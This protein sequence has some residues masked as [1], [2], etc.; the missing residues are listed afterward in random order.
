MQIILKV[1][2]ECNLA[3]SYC[4]EGEKTPKR[5]LKSDFFKLVDDIPVFSHS[6]GEKRF[7]FLF[8]GGEPMLYGLKELKVL[9]DYAREKLGSYEINFLMQTNGTLIDGDWIEFFRK[10]EISPGISLD[11][12]PEIHD[13]YRRTKTGDP[14]AERI[15]SN[16]K[17]LKDAGIHVGTLM[18][19]NSP[20]DADSE[21]LFRF[22]QTEDLNP[23]I[24]PVIP[25]GRAKARQD[26][27]SVYDGYVALMEKLFELAL[28]NNM[29]NRIQPLDELMDAI[30]GL[31]PLSECS[32]NG[33]CGT[34]F[35]CLYP[36]G[37]VGFCGRSGE[38]RELLYGNIR[39]MS[40]LELYRST[41]GERLRRRQV[42]LRENDCKGCRD[43][44]YCHG[45]CA[46]EALNM[47]GTIEAKY[48]YCG[49]RKKLL[50][51][52]RTDGLKIL[53]E[54]LVQEKI[55]HRTR[56]RNKKQVVKDIEAVN[57]S[58]VTSVHAT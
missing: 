46:F 23:K 31:A 50:H 28:Q 49:G 29:K 39:D 16:I 10:E 26:I 2:T 55:K 44:E 17:E 24:H 37:A 4:S 1:T 14:T 34:N 42:F 3:C 27:P 11:G 7:D 58:E 32:F 25:C 56:L 30:L 48:A 22:L 36:D 53:K 33:S 21:K 15:L 18:V 19:L 57:L 5:L 51:Y 9:T 45:G 43:W 52:L 13:K 47:F 20:S 40:L 6:T 8:H 41:N 38:E 35:I 12:Y 54:A